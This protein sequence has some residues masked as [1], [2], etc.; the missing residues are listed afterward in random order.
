MYSFEDIRQQQEN[1]RKWSK[2]SWR[3]GSKVYLQQIRGQTSG[4]LEIYLVSWADTAQLQP[5]FQVL[6]Y[7]EMMTLNGMISNELMPTT[8]DIPLE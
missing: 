4:Q 7:D 5:L 1:G 6:D 2:I 8:F 3:L